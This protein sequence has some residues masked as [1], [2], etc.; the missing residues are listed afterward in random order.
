MLESSQCLRAFVLEEL[1]GLE[2][3][4]QENVIDADTLDFSYHVRDTVHQT[5]RR[6]VCEYSNNAI[7]FVH[8]PMLDNGGLLAPEQPN[9][10]AIHHLG[11]CALFVLAHQLFLHY[12]QS[13]SD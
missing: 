11:T 1:I 4:A 8:H 2:L 13:T 6:L 5:N 7:D 9:T 10:V 3:V 12:C